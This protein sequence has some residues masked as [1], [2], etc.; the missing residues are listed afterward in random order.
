M[1]V[2]KHQ[3]SARESRTGKERDRQSFQLY[4]AVETFAQGVYEALL[5]A[6]LD[7]DG[8]REQDQQ[9]NNGDAGNRGE[10]ASG[11]C[12]GAGNATI[13]PTDVAPF[14]G[15]RGLDWR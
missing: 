11:E 15:R 1:L 10:V 8:E 9:E 4:L 5:D 7:S 14:T 12:H 3:S 6:R 2:T 13:E